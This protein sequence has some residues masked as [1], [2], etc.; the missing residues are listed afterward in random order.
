MAFSVLRVLLS[1]CLHKK[2]VHTVYKGSYGR[3]YLTC[4]RVKR[5]NN[6]VDDQTLKIFFLLDTVASLWYL[7]LKKN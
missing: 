4:L 2:Q 5:S 3:T 7:N 1:V 6:T